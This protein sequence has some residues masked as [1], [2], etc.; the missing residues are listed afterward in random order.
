MSNN[1]QL[2][3]TGGMRGLVHRSDQRGLVRDLS[4]TE[5]SRA[6]AEARVEAHAEIQSLKVQAVGY[7]GQQAM[8]AVAMVSQLEGQ[9]AQACPLAVTRLQGIADMT[10]MAIAQVV[11]DTAWKLH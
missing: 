2:V 5:R 3:P 4:G 10:S 8:Q 6:L 9:L 1:N 11:I 7:V